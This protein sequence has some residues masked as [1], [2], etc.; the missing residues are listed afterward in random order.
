MSELSASIEARRTAV[1]DKMA[2]SARKRGRSVESVRLVVVTKTQPLV[3]VEAA[4]EAGA[5]IFGE[6]YAEEAAEKIE[7][8]R[9]KAMA[10]SGRNVTAVEWHM[11]GHIQSRKAELVATHFALVHSLDSLKLARRLDREAGQLKREI[12]VLLEFNVGGEA[13]KHGWPAADEGRWAELLQEMEAVSALPNLKVRGL[14][15]M[16]PL[17]T[18][19]EAARPYFR[20]LGRLHDYL[21]QHEPGISLVELS[22]GTSA[23]YQ[24]AIEEGATLVRIGQAILGPRPGAEV[25]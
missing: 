20:R 2:N 17:S 12:P 9:R 25:G 4:L 24:V 6:N 3:V 19:P 7:A 14:M 13:S 23:D 15:T 10:G 22:M 21:T 8:L 11:I 1:L 16:P 18:D 5:R